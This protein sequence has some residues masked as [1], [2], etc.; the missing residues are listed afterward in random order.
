[1]ITST[2]NSLGQ[3]PNTTEIN[4]KAELFKYLIHWRWFL[5]SVLLFILFAYCYLSIASPDYRIY[6]R[7][8]IK[9][10]KSGIGQN[11][12]LAQLNMFSPSKVVDNEI[13]ILTSYTLMESVVKKLNLNV[14]YYHY[15]NLRKVEL[16]G[17]TLPIE[18]TLVKGSPELF[19]EPLEIKL[20]DNRFIEVNEERLP[21]G[22]VTHV[23]NGLLIFNQKALQSPVQ[24]MTV[25]IKPLATITESIIKDLIVEASSKVSSVLTLEME[26]SVPEKGIDILNNL[27][28]AYKRA[29]LEDKNQFAA[30]TLS[31]IEERLKF[32]AGDLSAVEKSVENF[33]SRERITNIGA[34]SELYLQTV[35]ENDNEINKVKIQQSILN[36][37]RRYI[38]NSDSDASMVPATLGIS[39]P[40]LLS[41]IGELSRL[42]AERR[43]TLQVV[44][45]ENPMLKTLDDQIA[46]L[47]LNLIDN[48]ESLAKTLSSTLVQLE[49]KNSK[50]ERTIETVPGKERQLVDITRQ[51]SIKNNLYVYLLQKREETELSY[52]SEVSDS[53][54]VDQPRSEVRP[55]RPIPKAIY[56]FFTFLGLLFPVSIIYLRDLLNDKIRSKAEIMLATNIPILGQIGHN[57]DSNNL[58]VHNNAR[59]ALSEQFRA[60][61]TNLSFYIDGKVE[62]VILL[63]S[64]M[65]G[66]GKSFISLNMASILAI[67]GKRVLLM[68]LDLRKPGL[69]PK[70][71]IKNNLGFTNYIIDTALAPDDII[72]ETDLSEN[73]SIITS[74]TLPPNPAELLL[75]SRNGDL[76]QHLKN[77]FDYIIIDAPPI[78]I[79]ADAQLLSQFA[80]MCVY[81]VRQNYTLKTQLTIVKELQVDSKMK[82][83]SIVVND[84]DYSKGY[85]YG[86]GYGYGSY[87]S[88]LDSDKKSIFTQF[89]RPKK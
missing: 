83:L 89:F 70:L 18:V 32:I 87:D 52:A 53:R 4:L 7:I 41:I 49:S 3:S 17:S 75:H 24:E 60:L 6:S 9:D 66:E 13:D 85:G 5:F 77:K 34:E 63:T 20:V 58:I 82:K 21:L 72:K 65:S 79:V 23:N 46:A 10:Q 2:N 1:M 88:A 61:R 54:I 22:K 19:S 56:F 38:N 42:Q 57:G 68:E 8:L 67:S 64:S 29:G 47:K 37:I 69:S 48:V 15:E 28:E 62:K 76:M 27:I 31:F 55:V 50:L 51:Q 16:Y 59:S 74:G 40:T 73:I 80:D 39:D 86:Y 11:D 36:N 14:S 44:R 78:G 35:K 45:P 30:N 71:G 26:S 33:K 84:I 25:V 43:S 81:V 12:A